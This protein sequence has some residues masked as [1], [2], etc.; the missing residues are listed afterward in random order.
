MCQQ[1]PVGIKL[2]SNSPHHPV[3]TSE[4]SDCSISSFIMLFVKMF[5]S[6]FRQN[7]LTELCN[8]KNVSRKEHYFLKCALWTFNLKNAMR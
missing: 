2:N 5:K 4:N 6:Q 7:I 8:M 1:H 3:R